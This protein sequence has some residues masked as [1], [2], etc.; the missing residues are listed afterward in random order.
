MSFRILQLSDVHFGS[1][2]PELVD[3]A[4]A[5]ASELAP[6]LVVLSGD[7][8]Q[9]GRLREFA[10][11]RAFMA[12]LTAPVLA[13]PGNHDIP[14]FNQ[15]ALRVFNPF[16]RYR[17]S[18]RPTLHDSHLSPGIA[19]LGLNSAMAFGPWFDWSRGGV[20]AAGRQLAREF[21]ATVEPA[22]LRV[23][24]IH[25]PVI[26]RPNGPANRH[27]IEWRAP[28]L[29]LL[30]ELR[31]DLVLGGHYHLAYHGMVRREQP[32]AHHLVVAQA[33]TACSHRRRGEANGFNVVDASHDA[34]NITFHQWDGNRFAA[35][36]DA[37]YQRH[38][39]LWHLV[40][41]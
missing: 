2:E 40:H 5:M 19:I 38:H 15:F 27:L 9:R 18:V 21:F 17:E 13:I 6:D 26:G 24:T 16:K 39:G 14:A 12:Q 32:S 1:H 8:T 37:Q 10:A 11:A 3:A 36:Q 33:A 30:H 4:L 22:A 25:H 31:I 7:L 34:L 20:N 29:E 23:L 35:W 28:L 41:G